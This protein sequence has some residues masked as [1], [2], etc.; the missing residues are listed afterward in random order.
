MT[1]FSL[2]AQ[3]TGRTGP[4]HTAADRHRLHEI[5]GVQGGEISGLIVREPD[6]G[7]T[8]ATALVHGLLQ[9]LH[10][11]PA[12]ADRGGFPRSGRST[13]AS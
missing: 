9:A 1:S 5:P 10:R 13:S 7:Q 6:G 2:N 8:P 4:E 11:V 3:G 12:V